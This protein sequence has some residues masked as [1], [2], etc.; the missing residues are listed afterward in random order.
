MSKIFDWIFDWIW[1]AM[2]S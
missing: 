1:E 2:G